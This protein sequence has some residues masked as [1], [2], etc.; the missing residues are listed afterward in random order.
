MTVIS[1]R[2]KDIYI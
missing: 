1:W 2:I